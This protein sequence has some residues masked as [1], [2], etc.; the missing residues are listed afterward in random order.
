[1]KS[2]GGPGGG[3]TWKRKYVFF[4]LLAKTFRFYAMEIKWINLTVLLKNWLGET[5]CVAT[6]MKALEAECF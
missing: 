5:W 3:Q 6:Q 4:F 2:Y 1:M